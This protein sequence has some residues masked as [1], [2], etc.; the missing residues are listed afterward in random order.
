MIFGFNISVIIEIAKY[1]NHLLL[2]FT[3]VDHRMQNI[4]NKD[5]TIFND[6]YP[7]VILNE[8]TD[9]KKGKIRYVK[10]TNN[11]I[12]SDLNNYLYKEGIQS[13]LIEGGAT[14]INSFLKS[15]NWDEAN[16]LIGDKEFKNG[17]LSPKITTHLPLS[18][19]KCGEDKIINYRN[20]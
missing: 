20:D 13:L 9:N 10:Y 7:I 8:K 17:I 1:I 2:F 3:P 19:N 5:F 18:I 11:N 15:N 6:N 16:V 12:I 4:F 14:T